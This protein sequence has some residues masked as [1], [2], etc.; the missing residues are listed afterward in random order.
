M[1][2]SKLDVF[3]IFLSNFD[4]FGFKMEYLYKGKNRYKSCYGGLL[5]LICIIFVTFIFISISEDCFYKTN[6]KVR[7]SI[8]YDS[9]SIL[10]EKDYFFGLHFRDK[11][12]NIIENFEKYLTV[13]GIIRNN[14]ITISKEEEIHI[15]FKKCESKNFAN[16]DTSEV[17]ISD[18]L[19]LDIKDKFIL[20]NRYNE[21]PK[22]SL[23]INLKECVNNTI[24][25]NEGLLGILNFF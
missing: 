17:K 6:P 21:F 12:H 4:F 7:E 11:D 23:S 1:E 15:P 24:N 9:K 25:N 22:I 5:S 8:L 2:N 18:Y 3:K 14:T 19:C 20:M 16:Y 13:D 10:Q